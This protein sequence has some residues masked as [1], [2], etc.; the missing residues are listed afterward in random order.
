MLAYFDRVA[1]TEVIADTS[2]VGLGAV[3]VQ[4]VDG[5]LRAECYANRSLSGTE[6]RYSQ[7]EK[8]HLRLFS[9]AKDLICTCVVY[10]SLT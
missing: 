9:P 8:E 3:L 5:K 6:H 4:K 1:P 7:T 10:P 2:P